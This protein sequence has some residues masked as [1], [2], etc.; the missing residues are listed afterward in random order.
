MFDLETLA[1]QLSALQAQVDNQT[2]LINTLTIEVD[3]KMDK[4]PLPPGWKMTDKGPV[5]PDGKLMEMPNRR[6]PMGNIP[7]HTFPRSHLDIRDP[8]LP[9]LK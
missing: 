9:D 1:A 5:G 2:K 6:P 8:I 4:P 3:K 7:T